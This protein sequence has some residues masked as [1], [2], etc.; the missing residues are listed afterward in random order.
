MVR[1]VPGSYTCN[2][3]T[4]YSGNGVTCDGTVYLLYEPGANTANMLFLH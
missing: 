2:C 1:N 4:G 3:L